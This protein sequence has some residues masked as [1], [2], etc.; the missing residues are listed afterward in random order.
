M[1]YTIQDAQTIEALFK[2]AYPTTDQCNQVF[3]LYK[4]YIRHMSHYTTGCNCAHDIGN[5]WIELRD[6]YAKNK[7]LFTNE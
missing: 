1:K 7:I 5:L 4:K 6:Y 3:E 2:V